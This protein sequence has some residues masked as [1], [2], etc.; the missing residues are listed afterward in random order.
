MNSYNVIKLN[1]NVIIKKSENTYKYSIYFNDN[2]NSNELAGFMQSN[3]LPNSRINRYGLKHS[4]DFYAEKVC[5]FKD[6]LNSNCNSI[7]YE[8]AVKIIYNIGTLISS[9]EN[10]GYTFYALDVDNII[11]IDDSCFL[12]L[13]VQFIIPIFYNNNSKQISFLTPFNK[14][15]GVLSPEILAINSIPS[16]I[17]YKSIYYSLAFFIM[18]YIFPSS[19][20]W[21]DLKLDVGLDIDSVYEVDKKIINIL[22]PIAQ[23]KLY[24]FLIKN[25]SVNSEN[26]SLILI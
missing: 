26:R 18:N 19:I 16:S 4:I 21:L 25:L 24:W 12:Y 6:Y 2:I 13:G 5:T 10:N 17:T 1:N 9:L 8:Q 11:V 14:N 3:I 15:I 23:T 7:S 20:K 22:Q